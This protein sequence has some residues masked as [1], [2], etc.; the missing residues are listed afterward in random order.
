MR[1]VLKHIIDID[2]TKGFRGNYYHYPHQLQ[3]VRAAPLLTCADL[4]V[5][6]PSP[7]GMNSYKGI[8]INGPTRRL[9]SLSGS[10]T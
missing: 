9:S 10:Y 8:A 2:A 1:T 5:W 6:I 4:L 3:V 7:V